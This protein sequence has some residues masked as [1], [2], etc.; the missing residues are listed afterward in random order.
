MSEKNEQDYNPEFEEPIEIPSEEL[1]SMGKMTSG[2]DGE[3]AL[4]EIP[5]IVERLEES[6][7]VQEIGGVGEQ[8][9]G[10]PVSEEQPETKIPTESKA[11]AFFRKFIRW[12]AGILI[13][14]GLG[15][16]TG[17]FTLYRPAVRESQQKAAQF[18]Q[19]IQS[20]EGQIA[21]L[22]AQISDLNSTISGLETYKGKNEELLVEKS[23]L[24]LHIAILNARL[25]VSNALIALNQDDPA[26]A[27][28]ILQM[29]S[30]NLDQITS[31]LPN[32]QKGVVTDLKTRLGLV[33]DAI[34]TDPGTAQTD[35]DIIGSKL[36]QLEDSLLSD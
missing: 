15:V 25:D 18:S 36:L 10:L 27:Q 28:V 24:E 14:F 6:Q 16:I 32:D 23:N 4:E 29:T 19:E 12:T 2:A 35:L 30:D 8:E 33:L 17:I 11:R 1:E 9:E 26:Q 7:P 31:Y 20:A 3:T 34:S 5:S 22:N 21:D 13:I